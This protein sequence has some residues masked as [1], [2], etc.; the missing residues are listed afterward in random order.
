MNNKGFE[1]SQFLEKCTEIILDDLDNGAL[2]V[3]YLAREM[4]MSR[5]SLYRKLKLHSGLSSSAFIRKVK[6]EKAMDLL[7]YSEATIT[8]VALESG[9]H[10]IAYFDKCF[11]EHYGHSPSQL[12]K[13]NGNTV[14]GIQPGMEAKNVQDK[15]AEKKVD[16][17]NRLHHFPEH[18]TSF[19]G[20]K[21]EIA[22]VSLLLGKHRIVSIT[23]PGGC[24]K[25]RLA[26]EV[27][28]L[29]DQ[30]FED[31]IWF[32]DLSPIE[33]GSMVVKE[34]MDSLKIAENP[35][36]EFIETLISRFESLRLLVVLDN[37]EHLAKSC[38]YIASRLI[39]SVP[40]IKILLT[41]RII[42][43]I[44]G[45]CVWRIS[46]MSLIKPEDI[47]ITDEI[48][49]SEAM[50]L[51]IDRAQL[52]DHRFHP[53][54]VDIHHV[55]AICNKVDGIPL[56]IELV[57]SRIRYMDPDMM[58]KRL[59]GS[60]PDID[61]SDPGTVARQRT[62][63]ATIQWSYNLLTQK[64]K[65][66][67]KRLSVF[68]GG[69]DLQAV[70]KIC[71]D[72]AIQGEFVLDFLSDL[73]DHSMIYTTRAPGQPI[74]YYMLETLR[75]FG[76]ELLEDHEDRRLRRKHLDYFN[77][78][79]DRAY[80][81]R[82]TSQAFWIG[83]ILLERDN[84]QSALNW[85][86]KHNIHQHA[87]LAASLSWFWAKSNNLRQGRQLCENILS[88]G[89]S[90]KEVMAKILQN[91]AWILLS[92]S[93]HSFNILDLIKQ[94][95]SLWKRLNDSNE[96]A[97]AMADL[98][99]IYY[100]FGDDRSGMDMAEKAYD[101]AQKEDDPGVLL[102]TMM[103]LSQGLVNDRK[104]DQARTM[105]KKVLEEG[106]KLN[107]LIAQFVGHHNT[108]DCALMEGKYREA[109]REYA[110]G[111]GITLQSGDIKYTYTDLTGL[112][113]AV[114]GQGRYKKSMQIMGGVN[115]AVQKAG[116]VS[117]EE[118]PMVFWKEMVQKHIVGTRNK[119]GEELTELHESNGRIMNINQ[120]T[121][122]ALDLERD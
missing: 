11:R 5:S 115:K 42:L 29:L 65:I 114:A 19:I 35:N 74:R 85:A 60:F 4:G 62:L 91:Y 105:A 56:A 53:E 1:N 40:G 14:A 99:F 95:I 97:V 21:K 55:A 109:E 122:Y 84:M 75:H 79:A 17:A 51:F 121:T 7:L 30:V 48:Y 87:V 27:V 44:K 107:N 112:A 45:E 32:V 86:E 94:S 90:R 43:N 37:C 22:E 67:F 81:G 31:G 111:I 101:L 25:T 15:E 113:M 83:K 88:K 70:E 36:E 6:L 102:Y 78:L 28:S 41:S 3:T 2:D 104:F 98:S 54:D 119:L 18:L 24:G 77:D 64:E 73:V 50:Q 100:G 82:L 120:L 13:N 61:S 26:C 39:R 46:P 8:E 96:E 89:C 10:T 118:I 71:N 12:R 92:F 106:I 72:H 76:A 59:S 103:T 9:F 66:L 47:Q 108:A 16:A 34:I 23:G 80:R 63:R 110:K 33:N 38:A 52:S 117:P 69:F 57:A 93:D 20:R 49:G 68:S 58:L 116:Q